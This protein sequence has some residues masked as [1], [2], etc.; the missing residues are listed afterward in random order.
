MTWPGPPIPSNGYITIIK[1]S[2]HL[3][4]GAAAAERRTRRGEEMFWRSEEA[5]LRSQNIKIYTINHLIYYSTV[6]SFHGCTIH[7]TSTNLRFEVEVVEVNR[8][9]IVIIDN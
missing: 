4:G 6:F 8:Y 2:A 1:S 3:T 7:N 9:L 5:D